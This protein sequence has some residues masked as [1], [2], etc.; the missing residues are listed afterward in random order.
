MVFVLF[1]SVLW[2]VLLFCS[3]LFLAQRAEKDQICR[4][5]GRVLEQRMERSMWANRGRVPG[6]H[7]PLPSAYTETSGSERSAVQKSHKEDHGGGGKGLTVAVRWTRHLDMSRGLITPGSPGWGWLMIQ[8]PKHLMTPGSS[9]KM[10]PS[11]TSRCILEPYPGSS[12]RLL[13]GLVTL[14]LSI[15]PLF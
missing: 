2:S 10:C 4:A 9:L 12:L 7:W 3:I 8:D 15:S 13:Y 14:T 1:Y 5:G 6:L 11:S